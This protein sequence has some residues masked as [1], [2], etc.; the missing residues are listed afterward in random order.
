MREPLMLTGLALIALL[1]VQHFTGLSL[2]GAA[3][4]FRRSLAR[5]ARA[6]SRYRAPAAIDANPEILRRRE[7]A[8]VAASVVEIVGELPAADIE[9]VLSAVAYLVH[10]D[11]DGEREVE[12]RVRLEQMM[13]RG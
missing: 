10:L 5:Q 13:G 12:E 6:P 2:V 4:S 9:P 3:L 1:I 7:I 11:V 8:R